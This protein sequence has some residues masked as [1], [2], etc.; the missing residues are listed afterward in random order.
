MFDVK[1]SSEYMELINLRK[2]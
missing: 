1:Y 2:K